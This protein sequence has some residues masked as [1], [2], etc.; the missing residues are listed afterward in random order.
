MSSS[1][2][3]AITRA[4]ALTVASLAG[5]ALITSACD[6][7]TLDDSSLGETDSAL[8]GGKAVRIAEGGFVDTTLSLSEFWGGA[9][10]VT[11]WIHP[12]FTFHSYG[13]VFASSKDQQFW[14]GAGD[15]RMG[16][17]GHKQKGPPVLHLKV[18]NKSY[19]Y[20]APMLDRRAWNHVA[21]TRSSPEFDEYVG[22]DVVYYDVYVNGQE[23][24][25]IIDPE[26]F[27]EV[28]LDPITLLFD[29]SSILKEALEEI[30]ED[31]PARE[32]ADEVSIPLGELRL[33]RAAAGRQWYGLIDDVRIYDQALDDS[34]LATAIA[35]SPDQAAAV[36]VYSFD[37]SGEG[38]SPAAAYQVTSPATRVPIVGNS[39]D[40]WVFDHPDYASP[41][42]VE[43]QLPI[44]KGEC[45]K[46][47]QGIDTPGGSHNGFAAFSWD[48]ARVGAPAGAA[49]TAAA[50]GEVVDVLESDQ[51]L[52][53][54]VPREAN[55]VVILHEPAEATGYLHLETD[56]FT[57]S[58]LQGDPSLLFYP[59]EGNDLS[60]IP[61]SMGEAIGTVGDLAAHLHF[62]MKPGLSGGTK[63]MAFVDYEVSDDCANWVSVARGMPK[64]GSYVR[65]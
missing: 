45:W 8:L 20:E 15:Y 26:W 57:K 33:G 44:P 65:R 42:A 35:D 24:S 40:A 10:T 47:T 28:E 38:S 18:A 9:F 59:D 3:D 31:W 5:L 54:D 16:S 29:P 13:A 64:A 23:L 43:Y 30:K 12:E 37:E 49:V 6:S 21:V 61:V 62:S 50:A 25:P 32:L 39:T 46:V 41:T 60:W 58:F 56:S 19:S 11:A 7:V 34:D 48:F 55:Y 53:P 36:N 2:D 14:F 1:N 63:P 27:A 51:A 4:Y 17:G 22:A 52:D